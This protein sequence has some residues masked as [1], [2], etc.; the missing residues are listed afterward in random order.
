M[1]P[2]ALAALHA[3]AF[4]DTP[5]PWT[6]AEFAALLAEPATILV[7]RAGRVRARPGR[8]AE[9]ELL[10]LA[11]DPGG[12]AARAGRALVAAFEAEAAARG[13]E[14]AFLEV[15]VTNARGARALRRARLRAGGRRRGYYVRGG[16]PARRCPRARASRSRPAERPLTGSGR[17][18]FTGPSHGPARSA[19][20]GPARAG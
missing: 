15:A 20:A 13:A 4:T 10:T 6:A 11:V 3:L 14:E 19:R 17:Y 2:E 18:A 7:D 5:R 8:R 9:A 16:R 12:A 1:T